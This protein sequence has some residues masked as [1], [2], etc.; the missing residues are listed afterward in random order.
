MDGY[1]NYPISVSAKTRNVDIRIRIRSNVVTK[2]IYPNS[3][4]SVFLSPIPDLYS[5]I[6]GNIRI[7][8]G[9]KVS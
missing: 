7:L 1:P 8:K 4:F 9:N 6:S 2:C 5:T 3:F